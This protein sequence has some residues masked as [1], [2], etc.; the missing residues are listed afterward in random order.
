MET[1]QDT[2]RI[3]LSRGYLPTG[4]RRGGE[5]LRHRIKATKQEGLT[6]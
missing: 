4:D 6:N 2:D 3:Q 1:N 5:K